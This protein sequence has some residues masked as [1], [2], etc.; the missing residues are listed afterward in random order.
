M[1]L[2]TLG[3]KRSRCLRLIRRVGGGRGKTP[4]VTGNCTSWSPPPG[5]WSQE[6]VSLILQPITSWSLWSTA[7]LC[8]LRWEG[9]HCVALA[10]LWFV[11]MGVQYINKPY[12]LSI[13]QHFL[14]IS[15]SVRPFLKISISIRTFLRIWVSISLRLFLKISISILIRLFLKILIS[16]SIRG[17]YKIS[18]SISTRT[19]WVKKSIFFSAESRWNIDI[20]CR[21]IVIFWH[22]NEILT[23]FLR[24]SLSTKYW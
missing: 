20:D 21:Y 12:Q 14:K 6:E 24:I 8:W 22:I 17:F 3:R 5:Q 2:T 4:L 7:E 18:I 9:G 23:L 11:A 15:I 13:Y 19:F 16:I 10:D 1:R